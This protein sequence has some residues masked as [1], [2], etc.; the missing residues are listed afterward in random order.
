MPGSWGCPNHFAKLRKSAS[1]YS[2]ENDLKRQLVLFCGTRKIGLEFVHPLLVV[3]R[4]FRKR[5]FVGEN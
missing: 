3:L 1:G 5:T 2:R 4:H